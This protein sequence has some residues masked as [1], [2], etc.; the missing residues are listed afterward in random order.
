MTWKT[1]S[2]VK[3]QPGDLTIVVA[4]TQMFVNDR[5]TYSNRSMMAV[6]LNKP[7]SGDPKTLVDVLTKLGPT[8]VELKGLYYDQELEYQWKARLN[9]NNR[10]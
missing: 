7:I 8:Q 6:I 3:W 2:W 10:K 5:F 4:Y 1:D 9:D